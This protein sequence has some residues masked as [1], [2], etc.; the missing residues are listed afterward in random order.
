[1]VISHNQNKSLMIFFTTC[2]CYSFAYKLTY[3]DGSVSELW[4]EGSNLFHNKL[5]GTKW[6]IVSWLRGLRF[7]EAFSPN[8]RYS[9]RWGSASSARKWI[10]AIVF[11]YE[12]KALKRWKSCWLFAFAPLLLGYCFI[13]IHF[14]ITRELI[15][16][17]FITVW[18]FWVFIEYFMI[19]M[20]KNNLVDFLFG[21]EEGFE[22]LMNRVLHEHQHSLQQLL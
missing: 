18:W 7:S 19:L 8:A 21:Y 4:D 5:K 22:S 3:P 14:V 9:F 12:P 11:S 16:S 10:W 17:F 20:E 6:K 13:L 2:T 1:M 15:L